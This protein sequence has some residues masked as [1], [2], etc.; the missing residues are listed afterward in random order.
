VLHERVPVGYERDGT[1]VSIACPSM[2]SC[3]AVGG[4]KA[5]RY[6]GTAWSLAP[7]AAF[8]SSR[9]VSLSSVTCASATSCVA[10]GSKDS[11]FSS[12]GGT[13]VESWDGAQ[14]SA[15]AS[16][17]PT[18]GSSALLS[19]TCT[20]PSFCAA[21]G[22]TYNRDSSPQSFIEQ[23]DGGSWSI[24]SAPNLGPG[25]TSIHS[26][27]CASDTSCFAIADR[28]KT[29]QAVE[30]WNG[31]T[32][33][34]TAQPP[35]DPVPSDARFVAVACAT[36]TRCFAVGNHTTTAHNN[37]P[38]SFIERSAGNAWSVDVSRERGGASTSRLSGVSCPGPKVCFAVGT[39]SAYGA[40]MTFVERWNG[41]TWSLMDSPNVGR[42][43][44]PVTANRLTAVSCPSPSSC[45]AVGRTSKD[46]YGASSTYKTLTVRWNRRAWSIVP[47]PNAAHGAG[48]LASVSCVSDRA[49]VAVGNASEFSQQQS[50]IDS[51]N[52]TTWTRVVNADPASATH[53]A[54]AGVSCTSPTSCVAV[55][56]A[57]GTSKLTSTLT[58]ASAGGQW[59]I[60][61]GASV[62]GAVNSSLNA[63]V[64]RSAAS[65]IAVGSYDINGGP[66][67]LVEH[68]S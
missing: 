53:S 11:T 43:T 60:V 36:E 48:E 52:G 1:F 42:S 9:F 33:S 2:T 54:L 5:A 56:T 17:S 32:W 24:V 35:I 50:L 4:G 66:L 25:V 28:G 51:W 8:A 41:T 7:L 37:P 55:G 27:T 12:I 29:A 47:S 26:V 16:P 61:P 44:K 22:Q 58:K 13:A 68:S 40:A 14:W 20:S 18:S 30:H 10:V 21:V 46:F 38:F 19:V 65:C 39:W 3:M 31:S 64:C 34:P 57:S 67:T 15:V 59:S 62:P 6:D 63:V 23:S 49:C 45:V